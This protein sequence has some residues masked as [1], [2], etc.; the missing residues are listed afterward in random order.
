MKSSFPH[1]GKELS[2]QECTTIL[3]CW[4]TNSHRSFLYLNSVR[5]VLF[6][7]R[8]IKKSCRLSKHWRPWPCTN[9]MASDLGLHCLP[10]P[11][12]P[13][14]DANSGDPDQ[15]RSSDLSLHSLQMSAKCLWTTILNLGGVSFVSFDVSLQNKILRCK[16]KVMPRSAASNQGLHC[17]P[18]SPKMPLDRSIGQNHLKV[19][20]CQVCFICCK[21]TKLPVLW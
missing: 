15:T 21:L 2:K 17:L 10:I 16:W 5:L 14:L 3:R 13:N 11:K 20:G 4:I 9:S 18:K 8:C 12:V 7:V 19:K 1:F 6:V